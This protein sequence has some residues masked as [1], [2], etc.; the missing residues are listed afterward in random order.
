MPALIRFSKASGNPETHDAARDGGGMAVK[1]R[2]P[3]ADEWD[4]I[5]VGPPVFVA[6]TV[7]DFLELLRLRKPDPE[8][9]QPDMAALGEF[10]GQAPRGPARDPVHAGLRAP[11]QLRVASPTSARTRSP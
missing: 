3:G 8:T 6:R 5:A 7:D 1:L 4:I 10:L 9:G 11:G 2:P